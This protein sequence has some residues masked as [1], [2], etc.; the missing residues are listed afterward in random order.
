M[1]DGR[2]MRAVKEG[3][4]VLYGEDEEPEGL[5]LTTAIGPAAFTNPEI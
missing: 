1:D 2:S 5:R 3:L 4:P